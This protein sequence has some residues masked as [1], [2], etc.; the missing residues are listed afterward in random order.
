[1]HES[2]CT[3]TRLVPYIWQ[4]GTIPFSLRDDSAQSSMNGPAA[5]SNGT[6]FS[7]AHA[8][9]HGAAAAAGA[10]PESEFSKGFMDLKFWA[11]LRLVGLFWEMVKRRG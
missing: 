1:M 6:A 2:P 9:R 7:E 4:H 10:E 3:P 8:P 11:A 5:Q